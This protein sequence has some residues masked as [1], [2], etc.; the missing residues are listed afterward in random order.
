MRRGEVSKGRPRSVS[1]ALSH[2]VFRTQYD[3]V[4]KP[5]TLDA[6]WILPP[7]SWHTSEAATTVFK[8]YWG[9]TQE[10][11]ETCRV[12]LQLLLN[13]LP[14]CIA[15][16]LYIYWLMIDG[17]PNIKLLKLCHKYNFTVGW[18]TE[19][20]WTVWY[21]CRSWS[22][23]RHGFVMVFQ[24]S[25]TSSYHHNCSP[26]AIALQRHLWHILLKPMWC[27]LQTLCCALFVIWATYVQLLIISFSL[28]VDGMANKL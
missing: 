16:V 14:T 8:Y 11:S 2:I 19:L 18:A 26:E 3:L 24:M 9:W 22:L 28:L 21:C 25:D 15:L 27:H 4:R 13:I 20:S 17:N 10:T 5:Q 7:V 1:S 6:L 23:S 12:I